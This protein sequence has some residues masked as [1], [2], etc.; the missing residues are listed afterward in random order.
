MAT[1]SEVKSLPEPFKFQ[2]PRAGENLPDTHPNLR[3]AMRAVDES[4]SNNGKSYVNE[5]RSN[6]TELKREL[7]KVLAQQRDDLK[8]LNDKI[9]DNELAMRAID[10]G[11]GVLSELPDTDK[12]EEEVVLADL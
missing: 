4:F 5:H 1:T 6:L 11:L 7:D 2:P 10:A 8:R 9:S 3:A 12:T